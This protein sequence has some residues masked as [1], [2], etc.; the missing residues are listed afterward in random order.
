LD[1]RRGH[2]VNQKK[3]LIKNKCIIFGVSGNNKQ[4][5]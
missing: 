2:S 4:N 3:M 1:D 5:P